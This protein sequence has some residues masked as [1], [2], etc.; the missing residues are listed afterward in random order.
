M[1]KRQVLMSVALAV[2]LGACGGSAPEPEL[3]PVRLAMG[4]IPSVQHSPFYVAD[5]KGYFAENGIEIEF[6]HSVFESDAVKLVGTNELQFAL[7]SG[8]QVLLARAQGVPL[9]YVFEWFQKYPIAVVSK[10]QMG[11]EEPGDLAGRTVGLPMQSGAS[12]V[13]WRALLAEAG[14]TEDDVTTEVIGF[15]QVAAVSQETVEAA[16]GYASNEPIQLAQV[17]EAVNVIYVSDYVDLVANGLVTN[18]K[19]LAENPDLVAGMVDAISRGLSDA[20]A[21]PDEAFGISE[22]YVEGLEGEVAV[23]QRIVL[24]ESIKLWSAERLGESELSSWE[25]TQQVLLDMGFLTEPQ[26][27]EAAFTNEFLP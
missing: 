3:T 4:Y 25:T 20:I 17:H 14:L 12:Y 19:T 11:I 27:L 24:D 23:T 1:M 18:E 5:Q 21:S 6:D 16:V 8:E 22:N 2:L 15:T 26:D 10:P 13:G 7:V 9:V